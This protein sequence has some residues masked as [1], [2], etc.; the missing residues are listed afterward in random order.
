MVIG[1][2][3]LGVAAVVIFAAWLLLII[4]LSQGPMNVDFLTRAIEKGLNSQQSGFEFSVESTLLTWGGPTQP[5]EFAMNHVRVSR[6]DKTPVLSIKK[7]G[8]QLSKRHLVFGAFVPRVIKIYGP[9]LRIIRSE[10]GRF[11]LNMRDQDLAAEPE[12]ETESDT[13]SQ[14]EF[15]RSLISLLNDEGT[16]SL[17]AGLEQIAITD[18]AILYDDKVLNVSWRSRGSNVMFTRGRGGLLVDSNANIEMDKEHTAAVRSSFYY[19]WKTLVPNGVIY[20]AGFNPALFAQQSEQFKSFSGVDLPL[21]GSVSFAMDQDFKLGYGRFVLGADSGKFNALGLYSNPVPVKSFYT[22]GWFNA[23]TR[24]AAIEQL[25][26]DLDGP[27]LDVRAEVRKQAEGDSHSIQVKALLQNMQ[28]DHLKEYWPEKLTPDPRAWV[29]G[30]LSAGIAT[31]ATLNLSMLAPQG[32]FNSLKLQ[33]VG[34]Q[35]DFNGIKVDYFSPLMPVTKVGGKATYDQKSFNIDVSGGALGDM[36]VT[37]SKVSITDLDIQD[38]KTHSKIDIDANVNGSL[39]TAL[40]VLDSEPLQ[41]PQ[42][43]GIRAAEV[44]GSSDVSVN[45]KFPLHEKLDLPEVRVTAQ[46]KLKEVTLRGIAAGFDLTGGP[47]DVALNASA[48]TVKG[49]GKL[50]GMPVEFNWLKDFS[51]GTEITSKVEAKLPL[52][53]PAL[54]KFGVPGDL[55]VTGTL[56][57]NVTYMVARDNTATLLLKGDITPTAF[58]VPVADYEKK[59]GSPGAIDLFLHFN[60]DGMLTQISGLS[61][62]TEAMHLKGDIELGADGKSLKKAAFSQVRLGDTDI[63]LEADNRGADGYTIKVTGRQFD[64]S[65]MLADNDKPNSDEDAAKP[66]TPLTVSMAVDRLVTGKEKYIEQVRM[67][68]RRN[69]WSR[70]EQL[71]IDGTSGGK[72]LYLRYMPVPKGHTLRFEA[73]NAGTALSA[74]GISNGMRGGKLVVNGQPTQK[75]GGARDLSGAVTVTDFT[76]V[77]VPVLGRLLNAMSLSG[78]VELLNGKGIAFKK[79]RAQFQWID[80]GQPESVK[81]TRIIRIKNGETSGASLGLTFEGNIDNWANMLDLD[82]TIIPVS[83]LN[84]IV[85]AIPLVG[86]ILTGGG[87]GIFAATYSVKGPKDQP[88][89]TVNPLAVLA[90]GIF[91]K[92]F[93][94]K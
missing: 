93:F 25:H 10:D 41:Y 43:L 64:A 3:L 71:E 55:K 65:A 8:I 72:P 68:L 19:N 78:I 22:Q 4:R 28:L 13:V 9:A 94:E 63:A 92:L 67:F 87:K 36:Q 90:P 50:D 70:I 46:A 15:M 14:A 61:L 12:A 23:A 80:K 89:V 66:V 91:R 83:D 32:D 31:K 20:L 84:K 40:K 38:G 5:F 88:I 27:K 24:E 76:L 57:A 53:A 39:R 35:I 60:K 33:K 48:L 49:S 52:D 45:F 18:A 11:L 86:N 1:F 51:A 54:A 34:G 74:L 73:D 69:G 37:K 82:G 6:A 79:M 26:V 81:N 42:K 16:L 58:T 7:V 59:A 44:E 85:D 29:T 47:M 75:D 21:K 56:P 17:L 2:E 62:E 30:H 77:E